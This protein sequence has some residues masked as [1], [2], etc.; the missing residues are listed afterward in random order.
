MT[1]VQLLLIDDHAMFRAGLV[2]VLRAGLPDVQVR[3]ES[4]LEGAVRD[5]TTTPDVVLL[6]IRL[7]GL[8]GLD[9]IALLRRQWPWTPII[10]LSSETAPE[11]M[12]QA[13][14]RG[15][16]AFVSKA[17]TPDHM[18]AI[19]HQVLWEDS[20][21]AAPSATSD[22]ADASARLTPRQ[23]EVLDLLSQ[24]LP[25]KVIGRRLGL[26]EN[27]VRWHVQAVLE[28]LQVASRAEAVY[29]ARQRGLIG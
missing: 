7:E 15:A 21:V 16:T 1:S 4:S 5:S 28:F 11:T 27:T 29:V 10:M 25:N 20:T 13:M 8:N 6:D 18:L 2:L 22:P 23:N 19:I 26:T 9:G 24:G 17:Q 3:E 14:A 12:R